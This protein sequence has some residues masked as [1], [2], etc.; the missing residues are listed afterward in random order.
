VGKMKKSLTLMQDFSGVD[1]DVFWQLFNVPL[2]SLS[3]TF[4]SH[5]GFGTLISSFND[6]EPEEPTVIEPCRPKRCQTL[7]RTGS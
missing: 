2:Q 6:E 7:L 1:W 4:V 5:P 3:S